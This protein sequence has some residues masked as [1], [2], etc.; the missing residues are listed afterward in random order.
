M[1]H[2]PIWK[3]EQ[4][5]LKRKKFFKTFQLFFIGFIFIFVCTVIFSYSFFLHSSSLFKNER[6][7]F[8]LVGKEITL[9]TLSKSDKSVTVFT[10]PTDL[11]VTLPFPYGK[12]RLGSIYDLDKQE[13]K[14][15]ELF[16]YAV[17]SLFGV[18]IQ[19][20][21]DIPKNISFKNVPDVRNFFSLKTILTNK[22]TFRNLNEFIPLMN[23]FSTVKI[24]SINISDLRS[25]S[26]VH[27]VSLPDG[28]AE[29]AIDI[30][31]MDYILKNTFVD[32]RLISEKFDI[33]II[34][35]SEIEGLGT[36]L[37][38]ILILSGVNVLSINKSDSPIFDSLICFK[39]QDIKKSYTFEYIQRIFKH[40]SQDC[41]KDTTRADIIITIGR[42]FQDAWN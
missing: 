28:S 12:Y 3:K 23:Y 15:G 4:N 25:F 14:K 9:F 10:I 7:N 40:L 38:R 39:N 29:M 6:I 16:M 33:E 26:F 31:Q 34:N 1:R 8:L 17:S 20:S 37:G 27:S 5:I 24:S 21:W 30:D 42:S 13:N 41:T 35:G 11:S 18:P 22:S 32:R 36:Y 19:K 2:L